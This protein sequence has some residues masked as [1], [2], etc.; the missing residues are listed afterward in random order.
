MPPD[1]DV[2]TPV[3]AYSFNCIK[4][5]NIDGCFFRPLLFASR[6]E[7]EAYANEKL[8]LPDYDNGENNDVLKQNYT[9]FTCSIGANYLITKNL[10]VAVNIGRGFR[11][12]SIFELHVNG[13]HG[14]IAAF[15]IGDP[16]LIEETSLNTDLSLRWRSSGFQVKGA[17]YKNLINKVGEEHIT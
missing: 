13:E 4:V 9:V 16:N 14:G 15:Q 10:A 1:A 17:V 6:Q 3:P 7:I 8:A 11:A 12:P 2:A 5:I